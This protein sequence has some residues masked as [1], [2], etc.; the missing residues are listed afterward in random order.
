MNVKRW[1][2]HPTPAAL[3][4]GTVV[5]G[6]N[7]PRLSGSRSPVGIPRC[8]G[9]QPPLALGCT[10]TARRSRPDREATPAPGAHVDGW[11]PRPLTLLGA[12]AAS[13]RDLEPRPCSRQCRRLGRERLRWL[14]NGSI[15]ICVRDVSLAGRS[16]SAVVTPNTSGA[17]LGL[18]GR[19]EAAPGFKRAW[20]TPGA[21]SD[22][23]D[24]AGGTSRSRRPG[25]RR[26]AP[27]EAPAAGRRAG[28]RLDALQS[29]LAHRVS[30]LYRL[31]ALQGSVGGWAWA[32]V[33]D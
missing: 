2:R 5:A 33:R 18:E 3:R 14:G 27:I 8:S 29:V 10:A 17:Y 20:P 21:G 4:P 1:W 22:G 30:L 31:R 11:T 25:Q 24:L 7:H 15:R 12:A 23:G 16:R 32:C 6:W 26:I 13:S 9:R 28:G 19:R